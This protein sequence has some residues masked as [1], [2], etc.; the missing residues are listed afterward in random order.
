MGRGRWRYRDRHRDRGARR[1]LAPCRPKR[2]LMV[3]R[4]WPRP[5][6]VAKAMATASGRGHDGNGQ[7]HCHDKGNGHANAKAIAT[8]MAKATAMNATLGIC[9]SASPCDDGTSGQAMGG[10]GESYRSNRFF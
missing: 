2:T 3:R 7:G 9:D 10:R 8:G 4:N 6:P 5:R 1:R